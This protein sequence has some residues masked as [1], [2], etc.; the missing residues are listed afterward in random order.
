M[1]LSPGVRRESSRTKSDSQVLGAAQC[2]FASGGP[3]SSA[4]LQS[5]RVAR[6]SESLLWFADGCRSRG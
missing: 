2:C 3:R 6:G 4:V 1:R 5:R